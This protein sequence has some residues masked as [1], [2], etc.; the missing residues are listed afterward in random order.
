MHMHVHV[1]VHVHSQTQEE[2]KKKKK[3]KKAVE[4]NNSNFLDLVSRMPRSR[5]IHNLPILV[6]RASKKSQTCRDLVSR[7]KLK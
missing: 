3:K 6:V 7:K 4:I 1:H 5:N 2:E